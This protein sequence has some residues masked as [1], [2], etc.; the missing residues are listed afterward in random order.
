MKSLQV[1][2]EEGLN[3]GDQVITGPFKAISKGLNSGDLVKLKKE[4]KNAY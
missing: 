4:E 2:M 3:E 1:K